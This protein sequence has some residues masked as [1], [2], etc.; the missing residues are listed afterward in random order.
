MRFGAGAMEPARALDAGVAC[1][2]LSQ[3]PESVL[4][5]II[6]HLK[7]PKDATNLRVVNR[8]LQR[9]VSRLHVHHIALKDAFWESEVWDFAARFPSLESLDLSGMDAGRAVQNRP[10]LVHL[11]WDLQQL[12]H[13]RK[14]TVS[15]E[16]LEELA[17]VLHQYIRQD[18]VPQPPSRK[19][20][21]PIH[22]GALLRLQH[23]QIVRRRVAVGGKGA[24]LKESGAAAFGG[25]GVAD[26]SD[27][28]TLL[29]VE[30]LPEQLTSLSIT[31][32]RLTACPPGIAALSRLAYLD[33]HGNRLTALPDV[34]RAL[35]SL[36]LLNVS[37]NLLTALPPSIG[38]LSA[39]KV[40]NLAHNRF[41]VFPTKA[42]SAQCTARTCSSA[43]RSISCAQT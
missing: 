31:D 40:L 32:A 14:L 28:C 22:L 11:L 4:D 26:G 7:C 25:A 34:F 3:L 38:S 18:G 39:L 19:L 33:L 42:R 23:F 8:Q 41:A 17:V 29:N 2:P 12:P 35:R 24:P 6:S 30:A 20:L 27:G 9:L 21:L 15:A 10:R 16:M 13:L 1:C 5:L 37:H 36:E 43:A